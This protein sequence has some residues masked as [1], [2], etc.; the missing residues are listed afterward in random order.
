VKKFPDDK[1]LEVNSDRPE[2]EIGINSVSDAITM[3]GEHE[4][5][6]LKASDDGKANVD[7]NR[8]EKGKE[9][10]SKMGTVLEK[11]CE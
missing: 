3:P 1:F 7:E 4:S 10:E 9:S 5:V 11:N 2:G 6:Q 8:S